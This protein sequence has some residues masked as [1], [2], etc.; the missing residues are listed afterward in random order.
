MG[1]GLSLLFAVAACG[2]K[3]DPQGYEGSTFP[4]EYPAATTDEVT[5]PDQPRRETLAPRR[6]TQYP[7]TGYTPPPPATQLPR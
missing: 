2:V 4:N 3:G 5:T 1:L 6:T 7:A